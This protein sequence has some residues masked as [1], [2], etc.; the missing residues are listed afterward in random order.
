MVIRPVFALRACVYVIIFSYIIGLFNLQKK[1]TNMTKSNK[2]PGKKIQ[3]I[4][5]FTAPVKRG[6]AETTT[7]SGDTTTVTTSTVTSTHIFNK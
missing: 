3:R 4:N 1:I 2:F 5:G 6:V 7:T